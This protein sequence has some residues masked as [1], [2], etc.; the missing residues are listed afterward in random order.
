[1][2]VDVSYF[3]SHP[4]AIQ[5]AKGRVYGGSP[6]F[7]RQDETG[8]G[9]EDN[10]K[11]EEVKEHTE[12]TT[13]NEHD[14]AK[15]E[16]NNMTMQDENDNENDGEKLGSTGS[17]NH[18]AKG[19]AQDESDNDNEDSSEKDAEEDGNKHDASKIEKGNEK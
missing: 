4:G 11:N 15:N 13:R 10:K 17:C 8:G 12:N 3:L 19:D 1:M 5:E 6:V 14:I 7:A 2:C 9:T 16:R 18:G